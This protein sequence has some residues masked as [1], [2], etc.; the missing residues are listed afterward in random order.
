M[1]PPKT[2]D[3]Q[4]YSLELV[5]GHQVCAVELTGKIA[6]HE[7]KYRRPNRENDNA[8][9]ARIHIVCA[10]VNSDHRKS[11]RLHDVVKSYLKDWNHK[12]EKQLDYDSPASGCLSF[13]EAGV[14]GI[15][16]FGQIPSKASRGS[17]KQSQ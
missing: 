2:N 10:A 8:G 12:A 6:V 9:P 1:V 4:N 17:G 14:V 7:C 3:D 16:S 11:T 5:P 13:M 15:E